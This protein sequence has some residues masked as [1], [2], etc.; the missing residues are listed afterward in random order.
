MARERL[1]TS[2]RAT[3]TGGMAWAAGAAADGR[4]SEC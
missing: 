1:E 2:G 4:R 3:V